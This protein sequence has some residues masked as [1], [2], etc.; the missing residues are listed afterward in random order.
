MID[1]K[2]KWNN[3]Y[4][5]QIWRFE[6]DLTKINNESYECNIT[7]INLEESDP[8]SVVN[9]LYE[10]E[11]TLRIRNQMAQMGLTFLKHE[12]CQWKRTP[13]RCNYPHGMIKFSKNLDL[14]KNEFQKENY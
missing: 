4:T 10:K 2:S 11:L 5:N 9:L 6:C 8:R 14:Y 13:N 7:Q 12:K 3:K 1:E